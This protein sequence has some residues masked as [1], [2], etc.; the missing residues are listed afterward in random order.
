MEYTSEL[1]RKMQIIELS[2]LKD[3][4]SICRNNNISYEVDGGTLLGAVRHQGFIPWDDD[5]DV[6]MLRDDYDKFILICEEELDKEKYFLQTYNTDEGYRWG[7]A[8]IL[9]KGTFFQREGQDAL[10]MKRG[11]FID[12]FPCD[13]MP[14]GGL[15]KM[16]F[17]WACFI[18][19]KILYSPVGADNEANLIK[20]FIYILLSKLPKEAGT[21]IFERLVDLYRGKDTELVRTLGWGAP[22]E[23]VGFKREWMLE[24]TELKFEDMTVKAPKKYEEHLVHMFGN[25]YMTPPPLEKRK[26]KHT[27]KRIDL[28]E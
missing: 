1:I 4:D 7:Y 16:L 20:R 8:R 26:P 27:A 25:D 28:G 22:E 2:M 21:A 11:I 17:N 13:G 24:T 10:K 3:L 14:D 12:I 15:K 6:R 23:N 5:V 19:R 9:K 18:G